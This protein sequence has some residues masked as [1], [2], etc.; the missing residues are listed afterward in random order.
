MKHDRLLGRSS[1]MLAALFAVVLVLLVFGAAQAQEKPAVSL[2]PDQGKA[3]TALKIAGTGFKAEEE[4][5]IV[6]IL[7][8][9]LR[10]GLG[11]AK[12][13][14]V[15]TDAN[16]AFSADSAIPKMAKPGAYRIDII[17]SKGSEATA[18]LTVLPK[19]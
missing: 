10:V 2:T 8:D 17:G 16:G 9:G 3:E 14:V 7:G 12:V 4:V 1:C 13:E 11:T 15:M 6:L 18:T 19:E 5:D